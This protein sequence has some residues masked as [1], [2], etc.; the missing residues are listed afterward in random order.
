MEGFGNS[1]FN[2]GGSLVV[3]TYGGNVY[4]LNAAGDEWISLGTL[5]T[6]RFFHRLLPVSD[7]EFVLVGGANMESGKT[8][9]T[10]VFAR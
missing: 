3:S 7:S 2:I 1:C 10:P 5:E 9:D 4:E 6:G 8:L